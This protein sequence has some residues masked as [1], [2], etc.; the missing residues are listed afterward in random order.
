MNVLLNNNLPHTAT[1]IHKNKHFRN[2]RFVENSESE[3][4]EKPLIKV[5]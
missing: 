5:L 2:Q 1:S 3:M 4:M